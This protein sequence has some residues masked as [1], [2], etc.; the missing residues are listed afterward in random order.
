MPPA[1]RYRIVHCF[2]SPVGGIFRHVRDLAEAQ[3]AAGHEV[4][5]VFDSST[6]GAF[7]DQLTEKVR[8]VFSLGVT[9]VP[10]QRH[11][12]IGD[13]SAAVRTYR[14]I[15]KMRPD[16]LHGHG[17]K[18]GA[19]ARVFG[20][21]LRV[22]G[23]R[24]ARLYSPH[25]GSLHYDADGASG[26]ALFTIERGLERLTDHLLFVARYEAEAYR[27][28]I[29][30]PRCPHSVIH[31]GISDAELTPVTLAPD[32]ADFLFVGMMRDLKGPDLFLDAVAQ[33]AMRLGRRVSAAMV[34]DGQ[35]RNEL[36]Q[37]AAAPGFPAD[38]RFHM[39]MPARQAFR[40]GRTIVI[41]SRAEAFPYIVIEAL[42]AGMPMI[43]SAVGGIPEV[44]GPRTRALVKPDAGS[45]GARMAEVLADEAAY[46]AAMPA[47]E[48]LRERFSV[49]AMAMNVE[50]VYAT[51]L[52]DIA[53]ELALERIPA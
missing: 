52:G 47:I 11:I 48:T 14:A 13:A 18:G 33:T 35:D 46:R 36:M 51:L 42:G 22:S 7:E 41:P 50:R 30:L 53:P 12:G 2:R 32:A 31:N 21:V 6:G 15:R 4:G 8:D 5:M 9:R 38:I 34:G 17:A 49:H 26:K 44:F 20:T 39:P 43:A 23:S 10:M 45:I 24:V 25:G 1:Q 40:L 16:V 28:K 19:Y 29:G 3:A 27:T 37:R